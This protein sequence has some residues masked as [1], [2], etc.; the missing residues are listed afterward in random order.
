PTAAPTQVPTAAPTQAPTAAP[1]QAPTAVAAVGSLLDESFAN[2]PRGWPNSPDSSA[3]WDTQGYHL[4]PRIAGQHVAIGAPLS[5]SLADVTVTGLFRK[6]AGPVGGGYGLVI[7]AQGTPLDGS[8][9]GGRYYVFEVGDRGQVGAWRRDQDHW[10]DLLPWTDSAAVQSGA[11]ENG[12]VVRAIGSQFTFAVN[13]QQVAQ[14]S[15]A[16][17][18]DGAVG[19]FVGGD[20]NQVLL[21]R[22]GVTVP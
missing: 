18:S 19:V 8:D 6:I 15:D 21:E 22:F 14:V 7:R 20:G 1:T 16:A 11:A 13:N 5:T 3:F 12:V 10:V 9:Q 17:L 4:V 2:A